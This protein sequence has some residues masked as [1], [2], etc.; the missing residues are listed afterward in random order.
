[1]AAS[2]SGRRQRQ[3]LFTSRRWSALASVSS[4]T[5]LRGL[6]ALWVVLYHYC[7]TAQFFPNLDITPHRYRQ[8]GLSRRVL[9]AHVYRRAFS[10]GVTEHYRSFLMARIAQLY[11]LRIFT[12]LLF[13]ATAAVSQFMAGLATGSFES[14][15]LTGPRLSPTFSCC[16]ACRPV[17]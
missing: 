17:N 7:G 3:S 5:P 10:K 4:L 14:I 11:P 15:P 12:L 16:R 6:A 13:V 2:T 8:Q 1:M 9:C